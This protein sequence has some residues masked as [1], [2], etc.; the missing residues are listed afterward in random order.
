MFAPF[1][2]VCI[3]YQRI[4]DDLEIP[5]SSG[6]LEIRIIRG[7]PHAAAKIRRLDRAE[8]A[9]RSYASHHRDDRG[10]Y[11][12]TPCQEQL[13]FTHHGGASGWVVGLRQHPELPSRLQSG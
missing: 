3:A 2:D 6:R 9:A 1:T 7:H 13:N 8:V 10:A 12:G 4:A 11:G 5:A